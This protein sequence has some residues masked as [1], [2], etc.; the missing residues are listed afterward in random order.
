MLFFSANLQPIYWEAP[1]KANRLGEAYR[2]DGNPFTLVHF[3][4]CKYLGIKPDLYAGE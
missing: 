3:E 1:L 2:N 4:A